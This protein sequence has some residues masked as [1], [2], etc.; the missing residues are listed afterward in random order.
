ME[1]LN[2]SGKNSID[3]EKTGGGG[4]GGDGGVVLLM[5]RLVRFGAL[6]IKIRSQ[7]DRL[8]MAN[9]EEGKE[10]KKENKTKD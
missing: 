9:G 2:E 10:R 3:Q 8:A 5:G 1:L 7:D 6:A 4:G